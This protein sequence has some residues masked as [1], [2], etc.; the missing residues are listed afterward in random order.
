MYVQRTVDAQTQLFILDD[1]TFCLTFMGGALDVIK[2]GRWQAIGEDRAINLQEE[3]VQTQIHPA[4]AITLDRLEDGM[5]GINFDGYT[6]SEAYSPAF[7][8]TSSD[9]PP[10]KLTPLFS[11][12]NTTW[13]QTYALPLM[14]ANQARYI[15]IGD[16]EVD[17]YGNPKDKVR[18]TQYNIENYDAVRIGFNREQAEP[19]LDVKANLEDKQ[20]YFDGSRFGAKRALNPQI[21]EEVREQCVKPVLQPG[22]G[23]KINKN[24]RTAKFHGKMLVPV[25]VFNMDANVVAGKPF[26]SNADEK[27]TIETDSFQGM[28]ESEKQ[29]LQE[30]FNRALENKKKTNDFLYLA[31]KISEKKNR[32]KRHLP[33]IVSNYTELLVKV[34]ASGTHKESERLF[35]YFMENF[36]PLTKSLSNKN[37]SY[38]V[39]VVAS[40]GLIISSILKNE[41]ISN[42]VFNELLGRDFDMK[43][44]RNGT[45]IYNMACYFAVNNKMTEMLNAIKE[46]RKR[47]KPP[48]QF[49]KDRDFKHYWGNAEFLNAIK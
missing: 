35:F 8:I 13:S 32:I 26:F 11:S 44:H 1:K 49:M 38:N 19:A 20:L 17:K 28:I 3:R 43:T 21:I 22:S 45:L 48:E 4:I 36:Y 42:M 33:Q 25:K 12:G 7:A 31:K 27:S 29:K 9:E 14:E 5:I 23:T 18:I 30:T 39:S 15:F 47:G 46:A 24:K 6:L 2:A 40:Q 34:V 37:I 10:V 16:I 41:I